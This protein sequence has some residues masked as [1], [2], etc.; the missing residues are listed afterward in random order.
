MLGCET[1]RRAS[2]SFRRPAHNA[3]FPA[4]L[5]S[6]K[7]T[8][9]IPLGPKQPETTCAHR[10]GGHWNAATRCPAQSATRILGTL[11]RR[12]HHSHARSHPSQTQIRTFV[13][14]GCHPWSAASP[15]AQAQALHRG[16]HVTTRFKSPP[17]LVP[18]PHTL[19]A[20]PSLP[21]IPHAP[22]LAFHSP[23]P[24]NAP[25]GPAP[26]PT[27][28]HAKVTLSGFGS[29]GEGPRG[30]RGG[31]RRGGTHN[32][33]GNVVM[34]RA[35]G[36]RGEKGGAS[37]YPAERGGMRRRGRRPAKRKQQRGEEEEGSEAGRMCAT[38]SPSPGSDRR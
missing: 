28:A 24:H 19:R 13:A 35:S 21:P 5:S 34:T 16:G 9:D 12:P 17:E 18:P 15:A 30:V 32:Q 22:I 26:T 33:S 23:L 14:C 2:P 4:T 36:E 29:C 11:A 27:R 38:S 6:S 10:L 1:L 20:S 7:V 3:P 8:F 37:P 25:L 31:P